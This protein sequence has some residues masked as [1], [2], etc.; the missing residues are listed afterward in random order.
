MSTQRCWR[1][2][3]P[4][5]EFRMRRN[6]RNTRAGSCVTEECTLP[7]SVRFECTQGCVHSNRACA[8]GGQLQCSEMHQQCNPGPNKTYSMQK[9]TFL[10]ASACSVVQFLVSVLFHDQRRCGK[11]ENVDTLQRSARAEN[12]P[13][14]HTPCVHQKEQR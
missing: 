6:L 11:V 9:K 3:H 12:C 5:V 13:T 10:I 2:A 14:C 8:L 7:L 4:Q 1:R